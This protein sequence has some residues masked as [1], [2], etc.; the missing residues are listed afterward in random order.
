M[1]LRKQQN[2]L[3]LLFTNDNLRQAFSLEP[4]KI[5]LQNDLNEREINDLKLIL[6]DQIN[7]FAD[8]L[9][10][11]RLH[12]V[13]KILPLTK[14]ILGE[15]FQ[16]LFR[17]FS[18]TFNPKSVKKHLED[19]IEFC[20]FL[21]THRIEPAFAKDVAKFERGKLEFFGFEKRFVY[22]SF[23]YDV[24]NFLMNSEKTDLNKR[25]SFAFWIRIGKRVKHFRV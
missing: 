4:E 18:Q 25:K 6:S 16:N 10:G 9:I 14:K 19:A 5:G 2:L 3:A 20:G 21:Q 8:S 7:F 17:D 15:D 12:E 24:R 13:E 23:D 22:K 11:K 1:S